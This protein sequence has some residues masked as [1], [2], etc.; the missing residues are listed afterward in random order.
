M[1]DIIKVEHLVK[2]FGNVKAVDDISFTVK[3]G[4][5]SVSWVL[6]EP[7]NL[8]PLICSAPCLLRMKAV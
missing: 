6:T 2:H 7:A 1:E 5:C 3:K 8:P 4:S